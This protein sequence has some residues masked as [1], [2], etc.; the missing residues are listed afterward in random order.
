MW[1]LNRSSSDFHLL[2]TTRQEFK[3]TPRN[4]A[5]TFRWLMRSTIDLSRTLKLNLHSWASNI[6]KTNQKNSTGVSQISKQVSRSFQPR[7]GNSWLRT[8]SQRSDWFSQ[9]AEFSVSASVTGNSEWAP[10]QPIP[11]GL[12]AAN[13]SLCRKI[14]ELVEC[15]ALKSIP[16]F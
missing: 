8:S 5:R 13:L 1:R 7:T 10:T 14:Q 3:W 16:S 4:K 9:T 15:K 6:P 11:C 12:K 2:A